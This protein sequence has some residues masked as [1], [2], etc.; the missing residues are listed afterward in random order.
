M[1]I[2]DIRD[3]GDIREGS[4]S[5]EEIDSRARR[6]ADRLAATGAR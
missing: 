4:I 5:L 3:L 6:P 2:G 1:A